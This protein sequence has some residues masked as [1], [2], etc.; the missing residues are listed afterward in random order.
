SI[1]IVASI[2]LS[3]QLVLANPNTN[4]PKGSLP[5]G[6]KFTNGSSG[7][8]TE[9]AGGN[10]GCQG[11][12]GCMNISG[13]NKNNVIAWG[14]GFNIGNGYKVN[15]EEGKNGGNNYLNLDYSKNPSKIA[16]LLEG[17]NNN[18]FIVNPSGV[19]VTETGSINANRFVASTTPID[20][21]TLNNFKNA[22][23]QGKLASFSPVFKP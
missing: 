22:N 10:K 11:Y 21:T 13:N 1:S 4:I 18:I 3:N 15:F 5:N 9:I 8:I 12:S 19:I 14:G 23:Q 2:L 7:S 16:G 20:E 6:G 17:N